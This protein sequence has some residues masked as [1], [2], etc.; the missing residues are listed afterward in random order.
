MYRT[1]NQIYRSQNQIYTFTRDPLLSSIDES[2]SVRFE[3]QFYRSDFE[4]SGNETSRNETYMNPLKVAKKTAIY[5]S[6]LLK[7]FNLGG[8]LEQISILLIKNPVI[9]WWYICK[10]II[11]LF[12]RI[13]T[14]SWNDKL[15]TYIGYA[16]QIHNWLQFEFLTKISPLFLRFCSWVDL[17]NYMKQGLIVYI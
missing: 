14:N 4:T 1:Q 12:T 2:R 7:N 5:V 9:S 6:L 10:R 13:K 16:L 17:E 3:N 11:K 15:Q 8:L